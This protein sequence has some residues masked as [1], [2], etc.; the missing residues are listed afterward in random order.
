MARTLS[1]LH[2]VELTRG[3]LRLCIA[4]PIAGGRILERGDDKLL[5]LKLKSGEVSR[6]VQMCEMSNGIAS[7]QFQ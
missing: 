5:E 2:H 1:A 4:T 3:I 6:T 7:E